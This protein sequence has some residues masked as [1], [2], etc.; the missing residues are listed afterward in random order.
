MLTAKTDK[1]TQM[2]AFQY[3]ADAFIKKPFQFDEL[4]NIVNSLMETRQRVLRQLSFSLLINNNL[5]TNKADGPNTEKVEKVKSLISE[6]YSNPSFSV[7]ELADLMAMSRRQLDRKVNDLFGNS[8]R[9]LIRC[10]RLEKS[11]EFLD[12]GHNVTSTAFSVG[13]N[14]QTYFSK[15][16]VDY[17]GEP[18]TEYAKK[19]R[20]K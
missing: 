12:A 15:N 13:F 16:F 8:T 9:E 5:K 3:L 20:E 11:K 17:F 4:S 1:K 2:S 19:P 18:P 6:H 10:Y 14:S 7:Q